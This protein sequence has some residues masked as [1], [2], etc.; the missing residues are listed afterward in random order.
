MKNLDTF[1]FPHRKFHE[2]HHPLVI[3]STTFRVVPENSKHPRDSMRRVHSCEENEQLSRERENLRKR[4]NK[5]F[6]RFLTMRWLW[7][8]MYKWLFTWTIYFLV[9]DCLFSCSFSFDSSGF[10][11]EMNSKLFFSRSCSCSVWLTKLPQFTSREMSWAVSLL[12]DPTSP[13]RRRRREFSFAIWITI[14]LRKLKVMLTELTHRLWIELICWNAAVCR[15]W[16][17]KVIAV[18]TKE[19][20]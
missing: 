12:N 17:R 1:N 4:T 2:T 9:L 8:L 6:S 18:V 13:L 19:R 7:L 20:R 11:F 10:S 14:F 3:E 15:W 5:T 16:C